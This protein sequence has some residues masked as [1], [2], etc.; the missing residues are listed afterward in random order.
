MG[1]NTHTAAAVWVLQ[2]EL[3]E[4]LDEADVAKVEK[5]ANEAMEWMNNNLNLQNKR[6]LTLDP[7]IKAKEIQSKA[8]V[9]FFHI[10]HCI[11]MSL[12]LLLSENSEVRSLKSTR[13]HQPSNGVFPTVVSKVKVQL[14]E[15]KP[16]LR[17]CYFCVL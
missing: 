16:F 12:C 5:S 15:I 10:T 6:S 14:W 11:S 8:K 13:E 2:D 4:H 1:S 17:M 7:V 3:Y 9:S